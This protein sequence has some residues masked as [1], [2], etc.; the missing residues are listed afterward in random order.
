MLLH[1]KVKSDAAL[2]GREALNLIQTRLELVYRGEASMYKVILLDYSMP[3][4]D[5]P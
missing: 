4:M 1:R 2:E 3:E 5:G